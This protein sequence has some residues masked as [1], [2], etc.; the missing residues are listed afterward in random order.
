MSWD[1][2]SEDETPVRK[3]VLSDD[4]DEEEEHTQKKVRH[5]EP[6]SVETPDSPEGSGSPEPESEPTVPSSFD[7]YSDY[8][9]GCSG[10]VIPREQYA[11]FKAFVEF[12]TAQKDVNVDFFFDEGV[13]I[14]YYMGIFLDMAFA[15]DKVVT[16]KPTRV[17]VNANSLLDSINRFREYS[18][19]YTFD[20]LVF[21]DEETMY[22]QGYKTDSFQCFMSVEQKLNDESCSTFPDN[23]T[24]NLEIEKC[25]CFEMDAKALSTCIGTFAGKTMETVKIE[26]LAKQLRL[27]SDSTTNK[28]CINVDL[29][30]TFITALKNMKQYVNTSAVFASKFV[31]LMNKA[32]K[33]TPSVAEINFEFVK[34]E[35]KPLLLTFTFGSSEMRMLIP[36]EEV[37]D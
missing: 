7:K 12:L 10:F 31:L 24:V 13:K 28:T 27:Q 14:K 30:D 25:C 34:G 35:E 22:F 20:I 17:C 33:L 36:N 19:Q 29:S 6:A 16:K 15:F 3:H 32:L 4:E 5:K 11:H 1:S 21:C 26:L 18:K 23:E 37:D 8:K 2:E 9:P